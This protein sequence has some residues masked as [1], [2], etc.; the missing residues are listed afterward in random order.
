MKT[1]IKTLLTVLVIT[2]LTAC[3]TY[4]EPLFLAAMFDNADQCQQKN[5]HRNGG[6]APSYCGASA[7]RTYIYQGQVGPAVG[8]V[9]K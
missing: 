4:G 1:L 6:Q 5:W 3:G 2:Q 7:N 8:Y 9:K